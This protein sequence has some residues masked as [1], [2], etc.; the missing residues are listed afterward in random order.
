MDEL[1]PKQY[2]VLL[3]L[4]HELHDV[5]VRLPQSVQAAFYARLYRK[6]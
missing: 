4:F 6:D 3:D 5:F 2:A 1:S